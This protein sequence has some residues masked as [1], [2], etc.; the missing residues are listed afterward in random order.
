MHAIVSRPSLGSTT[1]GETLSGPCLG[2]EAG[3]AAALFPRAV[4]HPTV[5]LSAGVMLLG[6]RGEV[7][8]DSTVSASGPWL[9]ITIGVGPSLVRRA[10]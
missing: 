3:I 6:V 4:I 8:G 10:P 2:P 9:A 7:A 5:A 1:S